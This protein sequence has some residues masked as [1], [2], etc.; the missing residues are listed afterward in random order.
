M[1]AEADDL[2]QDQKIDFVVAD[3]SKQIHWLTDCSVGLYKH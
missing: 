2:N 1:I 3:V